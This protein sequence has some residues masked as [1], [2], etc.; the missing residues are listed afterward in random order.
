M[1]FSH[2]KMLQFSNLA[3]LLV[4]QIF[5]TYYI[6]D[7]QHYYEVANYISSAALPAKIQ[8]LQYSAAIRCRIFAAL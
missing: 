4:Q 6:T 8:H 2:Y 7:N 3:A 1:I 5:S